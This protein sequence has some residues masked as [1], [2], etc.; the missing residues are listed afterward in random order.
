MRLDLKWRNFINAFQNSNWFLFTK[1][2]QT[3]SDR[4]RGKITRKELKIMMGQGEDIRWKPN[5][6]KLLKT[7]T[8]ISRIRQL[9]QHRL[10]QFGC[11]EIKQYS[12]LSNKTL[13]III[14]ESL[15]S[16]KT[17]NNNKTAAPTAVTTNKSLFHY[18]LHNLN[19]IIVLN[20][21]RF[22]FFLGFIA[23]S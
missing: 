19:S 4:W 3:V 8:Q 16:Q 5:H 12:R 7:P 17:T 18:L 14:F 2:S 13:S 22:S 15:G 9:K 10:M 11:I 6:S 23:F 20:M 1:I 21:N